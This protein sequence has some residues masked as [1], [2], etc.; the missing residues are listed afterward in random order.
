VLG[1]ELQKRYGERF[2]PW[3]TCPPGW[4][5]Q[6]LATTDNVWVSEDSASMIYEALSAGCRV[7]I[8]QLPGTSRRSRVIAG[9][10][11]LQEEG[12]VMNYKNWAAQPLTELPR[13]PA[14]LAEAARVATLVL[15]RLHAD[16]APA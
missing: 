15:Q 10:Q 13:N 3:A 1:E 9:V 2:Q 16:G 5:A 12:L 4:L 6:R 8:L 14:P 11:R 7:G